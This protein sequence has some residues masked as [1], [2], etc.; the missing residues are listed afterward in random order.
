MS[1]STKLNPI[2]RDDIVWTYCGAGLSI[3]WYVLKGSEDNIYLFWA[4]AFLIY[5]TG[6]KIIREIQ[7]KDAARG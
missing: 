6:Q 5:A 3:I 2:S 4:L 7:L 1:I